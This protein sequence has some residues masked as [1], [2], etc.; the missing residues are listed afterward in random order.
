MASLYRP[1]S[2]EIF[3]C[4]ACDSVRVDSTKPETGTFFMTG[5]HIWNGADKPVGD[6]ALVI[7]AL[8]RRCQAAGL[9]AIAS[10]EAQPQ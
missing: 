2:R 8:C 4:N 10:A 7:Y 5:G 6:Y 9:D 3:W 1:K